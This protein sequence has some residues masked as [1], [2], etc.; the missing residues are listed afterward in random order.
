V[1]PAYALALRKRGVSLRAML[2][3]VIRPVLGGAVAV[4]AGIAVMTVLHGSLVQLLAGGALVGAVYLV[5]VYPMR[6][7]LKAAT[8]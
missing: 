2:G 4:G 8:A 6:A 3:H 1:L 5:A 7:T